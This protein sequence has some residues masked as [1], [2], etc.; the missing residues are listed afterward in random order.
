MTR[1]GSAATKYG[2]RS[3][4]PIHRQG[5]ERSIVTPPRPGSSKTTQRLTTLSL[6]HRSHP[7]IQKT[8]C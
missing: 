3:W 7:N 8:F 6:Q 5:S 4:P 2:K 1:A